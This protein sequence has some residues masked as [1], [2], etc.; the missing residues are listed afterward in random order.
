MKQNYVLTKS[1]R[2]FMFL[3]CI[4][5]RLHYCHLVKEINKVL[6]FK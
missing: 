6:K 3:T 1:D 2:S 4:F 5:L